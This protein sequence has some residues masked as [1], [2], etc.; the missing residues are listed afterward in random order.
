VRRKKKWFEE[1]RLL[2]G[3]GIKKKLA[4]EGRTSLDW[5]GFGRRQKRKTGLRRQ[6][7]LMGGGSEKDKNQNTSWAKGGC[8]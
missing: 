1:S 4:K 5:T 6:K 7:L 2:V 8:Q 3:G